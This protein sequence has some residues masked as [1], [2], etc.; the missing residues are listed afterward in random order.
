MRKPDYSRIPWRKLHTAPPP[1]LRASWGCLDLHARGLYGLLLAATEQDG[2]ILLDDSGLPS[3]AGLLY[4]TWEQVEPSLSA[5][6]KAKWVQ[7]DQEANVLRLTYF[8]DSQEVVSPEAERKRRQRDREDAAKADK[9][10]QSRDETVTVTGQSRDCHRTSK[11]AGGTVTTE[12]RSEKRELRLEKKEERSPLSPQE[13]KAEPIKALS[14]LAALVQGIDP[15]QDPEADGWAKAW[16]ALQCRS[17]ALT[18]TGLPANVENG[19]FGVWREHL[20]KI[21]SP[22][23]QDDMRKFGRW[24]RAGGASET[25]KAW[26]AQLADVGRMTDW[27]ARSQAWDG[28]SAPNGKRDGPWKPDPT[29][30]ANKGFSTPEEFE[31]WRK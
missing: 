1:S 28:V 14:A 3:V 8:E 2:A 15:A 23:T 13:Q 21:A 31:S 10:G 4:A 9:S 20:A 12:L 18:T 7:H 27:F 22:P 24:W 25:R 19:W 26:F 16:E 29:I 11:D 6:L 30:G 5:L 17:R